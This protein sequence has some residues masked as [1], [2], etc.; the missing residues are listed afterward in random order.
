MSV[1]TWDILYRPIV[2]VVVLGGVGQL[3]AR[4]YAGTGLGF[5]SKVLEAGRAQS[6]LNRLFWFLSLFYSEAPAGLFAPQVARWR[7]DVGPLVRH[8]YRP[9]RRGRL[10]RTRRVRIR[11]VCRFPQY[12]TS[13]TGRQR[14]PRLCVLGDTRGKISVYAMVALAMDRSGATPGYCR[15]AM[16][17]FFAL[18]GT[19]SACI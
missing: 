16:G 13:G 14:V 1:L 15:S 9:L 6:W 5:A 19:R 12:S 7:P 8:H 18:G 3:A 17:C 4:V 2:L 10:A 11:A